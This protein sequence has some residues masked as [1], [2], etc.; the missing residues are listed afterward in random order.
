MSGTELLWPGRDEERWSRLLSSTWFRI[1]LGC[2]GEAADAT[3]GALDQEQ[4]WQRR[5]IGVGETDGKER[6]GL[7]LT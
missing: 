3:V 7:A 2:G 5:R 6:R 1:A 4:Q